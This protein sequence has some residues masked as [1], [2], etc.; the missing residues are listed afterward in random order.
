MDHQRVR[1]LTPFLVP[2]CAIPAG[3]P[4]TSTLPARG[5]IIDAAFEALGIKTEGIR[6][7][8]RHEFSIDQRVYA[9]KQIARGDR[10]VRAQPQ[11]VVL[12]HPRV[13]AGL[14]AHLRDVD[15]S[16]ARQA[17][18]TPAFGAVIAGRGR[19]VERPFAFAP[20]ELS[21]M[22]ARQR[23]PHHTVAI[24]VG[25]A[26]AEAG[27]GHIVDLAEP[28]SRVETNDG[29]GIPKRDGAPDGAVGRI[30]HDGVEAD[31]QTLVRF[32]VR[33]FT[34]F[35]PRVEF[36]IAIGVEDERGP[37]LRG[38]RITRRIEF[39]GVEPAHDLTVAAGPERIVRVLGELQMV[40]TEAG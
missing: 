23:Y 9:V 3:D 21:Q 40:G 7:A 36:A 29:A 22:P 38:G 25:A 1:A 19:P 6:N 27:R 20:I 10:H 30:R 15:E 37:S 18:E 28:G 11:G 8:E 16:R 2:R 13:I 35:D 31:R 33:G 34:G 14:D 32:G 39:L 17:M 24:D 26:Y 5:G 4:D 12:I